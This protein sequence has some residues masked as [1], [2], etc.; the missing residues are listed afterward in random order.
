MWQRVDDDAS[1][2]AGASPCAM[3]RELMGDQAAKYCD[4][5]ETDCWAH[6]ACEWVLL[7]L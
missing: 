5:E 6:A 4:H 7:D 3:W 1:A 2:D